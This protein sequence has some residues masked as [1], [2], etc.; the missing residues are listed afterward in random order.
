MHTV[1]KVTVTLGQVQILEH[2]DCVGTGRHWLEI[3]GLMGA[4]ILALVCDKCHNPGMIER[5]DRPPSY[6]PR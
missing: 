3:P 1:E 4:Q 2:A 6:K 5:F